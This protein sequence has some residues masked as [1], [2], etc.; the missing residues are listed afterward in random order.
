ME[1][2]EVGVLGAT[3]TVGRRIV[4]L[5]ADHPWFRVTEVAGS[6]GSAGT[7]FPEALPADD[8]GPIPESVAGLRLRDPGEPWSVPLVLSSIPSAAAQEL[9]AALAGAGH[10]VVSNASA[11]RMDPTVP[12]VIPDVNPDQLALLDRQGERWPGGIVTNPNCSAAGLAVALAPLHRRFGVRRVVVTTLQAISGAGRPGPPASRLLDNVVPFIAGEEEKLVSEPRKILGR[13]DGGAWVPAGFPVSASVHRV[14]VSHG[15]LLAVSVELEDPPTPD[16]AA[17][18]LAGF[19]PPDEVR[20][21]P[22]VPERPIRVLDAPD[23]PQPRLDRDEGGGMVVTVGRVRPCP[24]LSLRF[25]VLSHNLFR[26]AA[27]AAV[28]NAELCRA[29]GRVGSGAP[30]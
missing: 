7:L 17:R 19:A 30:S 1:R 24:V 22:T 10:L 2:V 15:H 9:E 6:P 16:E 13:V 11:Y 29:R 26:G 3:G 28:M 4:R 21:L 8:D 23:R 25:S 27:G 20:A 18:V 5:L 12:L 14:S